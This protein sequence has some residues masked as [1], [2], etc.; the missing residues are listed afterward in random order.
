M[1]HLDFDKPDHRDYYQPQE[2]EF[3]FYGTGSEYFKIWIV[4]LILTIITLGIYSP[5]AKVRR[6]RYFYGN[7][8]VNDTAFDFV[9]NPKRILF[10][11][12]IA[13]A[14]YII[15]SVVGQISPDLAMAG[16]LVI[17][18]VMPWLMRSTMRFMA[19]NSQYNN[20]HF[21]FNGSLLEAYLVAIIAIVLSVISFGLL[22]P[23]AWWLFKRYQ[24]DNTYFGQLKFEFNTSITDMYKAMMMPILIVIGLVITGV[25]LLAFSLTLNDY[26]GGQVLALFIVGF[27]FLLLLITPLMQAY[28]HQAIW[29]KL[30]LGDNEFRLDNFSPI[31][32][33]VIQATNYIA[34]VLSLG[35]FYPWAKVRLHR[36][37][38]ETLTLVAYDDFDALATPNMDSVSSVAE[39]I[40][41]V[42]DF[43]VSW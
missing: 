33:A 3:Y 2:Y 6:L 7:T 31:R 4:N 36:Y 9:A 41:D 1:S 30:T 29:D 38:V 39:E 28:T 43:D 13:I 10:G 12:L 21:S 19:R 11:R 42:F 18:V 5:W 25:F 20:V 35:L 37:K 22:A 27:Y 24:F 14:I 8:E 17:F 40:S 34:I 26:I 16:G 32:F 23:V 15:I